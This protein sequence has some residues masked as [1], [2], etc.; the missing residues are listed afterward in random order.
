[1]NRPRT[2]PREV[3]AVGALLMHDFG[4]FIVRGAAAAQRPRFPLVQLERILDAML[5]SEFMAERVPTANAAYSY[6]MR[7]NRDYAGS[8]SAAQ[9]RS[10][11]ATARRHGLREPLYLA[12]G[13]KH[14]HIWTDGSWTVPG[15]T[16]VPLA[17][18][19]GNDT[20]SRRRRPVPSAVRIA[21]WN[22]WHGSD[23]GTG[24]CFCCGS[25]VTQQDFE[26][27]H[28]VAASKGGKNRIDNLRVLCRACNRSMGSRN[29]LEFVDEHFGCR[30]QTTPMELDA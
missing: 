24:S 20:A 26:A 21:L 14:G 25:K 16:D 11:E 27:G 2:W 13:A 1:M 19:R 28:V 6:V 17:A 3:R 12:L 15:A 22:A 30:A 4:P 18:E 7:C 8:A 23:S 5:R 10:A 9:R 29:L